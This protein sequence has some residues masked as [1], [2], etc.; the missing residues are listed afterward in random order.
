MKLLLDI[1]DCV[2]AYGFFIF[3]I[4]TDESSH[5]FIKII[6]GNNIEISIP[7]SKKISIK[8]YR[9]LPLPLFINKV[10]I[11]DKIVFFPDYISVGE[12]YLLGDTNISPDYFIKMKKHHP[13][14]FLAD[15]ISFSNR[16]WFDDL[17]SINSL[18]FTITRFGYLIFEY[19]VLMWFDGIFKRFFTNFDRLNYLSFPYKNTQK[20]YTDDEFIRRCFYGTASAYVQKWS[21]DLY[22]LTD[23]WMRYDM[24]SLY[25]IDYRIF[26]GKKFYDGSLIPSTFT[27]FSCNK[28]KI[29]PL[30]IDITLNGKNKIIKPGQNEWTVAKM[31]VDCN[32]L[33]YNFIL[34][35]YLTHTLPALFCACLKRNMHYSDVIY[36]KLKPFFYGTN[37]FT[38]LTYHFVAKRDLFG[39]YIH[40]DDF[41][42]ITRE[43]NKNYT[44]AKDFKKIFYPFMS[45]LNELTK[46]IKPFVHNLITKNKNKRFNACMEEFSKYVD[47]NDYSD[48]VTYI[49]QLIFWHSCM[50]MEANG[51][52]SFPPSTPFSLRIKDLDEMN[53][54]EY[55]MIQILPRISKMRMQH[56]IGLAT[57]YDFKT[58]SLKEEILTLMSIPEIKNELVELS[59][60]IETRNKENNIKFNG[61]NPVNT[62][63]SIRC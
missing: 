5:T 4:A 42:S 6:K 55:D 19:L 8:F 21:H 33:N 10:M 20:W 27:V 14:N 12:E 53:A 63:I 62:M 2:T 3:R 43:I 61:F 39:L 36:Q 13:I 25:V 23:E 31:C 11:D 56:R 57:T 26:N 46:I 15:W 35:I 38:L 49:L 17:R 59:K 54:D 32:Q 28:K 58:H 41:I 18:W 29:I 7:Y 51:T 52:F 34:H 40:V 9:L 48:T 44:L 22:P 37:N 16:V 45:D 60:K 47:V 24:E 1:H 30:F 50:H